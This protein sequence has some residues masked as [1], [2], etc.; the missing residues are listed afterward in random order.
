MQYG[1]MTNTRKTLH[2]SVVLAAAQPQVV[3]V[4]GPGIPEAL[5][6]DKDAIWQV[7]KNLVVGGI[8]KVISSVAFT[9]SLIA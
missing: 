6:F 1:F 5:A 9:T 3:V 8:L 4:Q 2:R 7:P